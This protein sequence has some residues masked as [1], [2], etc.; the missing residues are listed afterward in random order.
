MC[1]GSEFVVISVSSSPL[2]HGPMDTPTILV[3][4]DNVGARAALAGLLKL[5]GFEAVTAKTGREG[6]DA[7]LARPFDV[8]LV[9]LHL[10]DCSGADLIREFN[11]RGVGAALVLTTVFPDLDSTCDV[12]ALGVTY[13]EGLVPF[14]ELLAAIC[15]A[16]PAHLSASTPDAHHGEA[17]LRPS[18]QHRSS[19]PL[20]RDRRLHRV[21]RALDSETDVAWS[22]PALASHV[23]LSESRLRHLFAEVVGL[24][25]SRFIRGRRLLRAA[26]LLIST[27]DSVE[28]IAAGVHLSRDLRD[29]RRA[30]KERFG[31]CPGA[32]RTRYW[33]SS[34]ADGPASRDSPQVGR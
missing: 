17:A 5:H 18:F 34:A 19:R 31:T 30:F 2:K 27:A 16:I 1:A 24:S 32:Y 11:E 6:L 26:R 7:A 23:R 3:I 4:D 9:D 28:S 29:M 10:P 21:I 15:A 33:R 8:V 14:E 20:P 12:A 25:L 22:I 13:L